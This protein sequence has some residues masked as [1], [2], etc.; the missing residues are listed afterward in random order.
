VK[1]LKSFSA[2]VVVVAALTAWGC[3][4]D[5]EVM[6]FVKDFDGFTGELVKKVKNA[7]NAS[8]GVDGAQKYLDDNKAQLRERVEAIKAVRNFQISDQTKKKVEAS[9]MSNA[10]AVADLQLRYVGQAAMDAAF[11]RKLEK[12]VNDY[13][14]MV[15]K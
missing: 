12:L 6:G 7:P 4:R 13:R 14:D 10:T 11:G 3:S 9:F 1:A 15:V 5:G 2:W 8:V